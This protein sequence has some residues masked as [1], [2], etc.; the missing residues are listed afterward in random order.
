MSTHSPSVEPLPEGY[1]RSTVDY[2]G[3]TYEL[4]YYRGF[5]GSASIQPAGVD[6]PTLT[7]QLEPGTYVVPQPDPPV[8]PMVGPDA[9][10]WVKL[11]GGPNH[12]AVKF[13]IDNS[14]NG[15]EQ[16]YKGPLAGFKARMNHGASAAAS[17]NGSAA[18][19]NG[20][21]VTVSEG[22]DQIASLNVEYQ[23][24]SVAFKGIAGA[25]RAFDGGAS[26]TGS[27]GDETLTID[28]NASFCPPKC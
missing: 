25:A 5:V 4:T 2:E 3:F 13:T 20:A 15:A 21:G 1:A 8:K 7:F 18:K 19:A 24:T 22:A 28:D 12:R 16:S 17:A 14:P 26:G 6:G 10:S 23:P 27:P 9:K 11:K